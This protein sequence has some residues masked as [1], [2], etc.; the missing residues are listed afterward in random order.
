[1]R[2]RITY[3][4]S[5]LALGAALALPT[6]VGAQATTGAATATTA[7]LQDPACSNYQVGGLIGDKWWSLGGEGGVLGCPTSPELDT[8]GRAGKYQTFLHGGIS[9]SPDQGEKMMVAAYQQG[10]SIKVDWGPT[11][12]FKYNKFIVRWDRN[13]ENIGQQD[14]FPGGGSTSGSHT[15]GIPGPGTYDVIVEGCDYDPW[16]GSE[17]RQGWTIPAPVFVP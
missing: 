13:G 11:N 6:A 10:Q 1:M 4:L 16:S 14:V 15:F 8:P 7:R 12:P 9:W 5:A 2:H 17:C 3:A